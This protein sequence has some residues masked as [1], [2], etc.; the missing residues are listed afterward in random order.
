MTTTI[1]ES[2][3]CIDDEDAIL[4]EREQQVLAGVRVAIVDSKEG[5]LVQGAWTSEV[6]RPESLEKTPHP[7]LIRTRG[8]FVVVKYD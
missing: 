3:T 7:V 6:T 5:D 4:D 2:G 8:A 1:D